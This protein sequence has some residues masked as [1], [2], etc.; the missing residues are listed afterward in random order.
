MFVFIWFRL[1]ARLKRF[2]E[3]IFVFNKSRLR[4]ER[5]GNRY[6]A[7]DISTFRLPIILIIKSIIL[8]FVKVCHCFLTSH[9]WAERIN[10]FPFTVEKYFLVAKVFDALSHS[11]SCR[12]IWA[13]L[14]AFKF[15]ATV[16]L[17]LKRSRLEQDKNLSG[18]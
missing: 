13:A 1:L 2:L 17:W 14:K 4:A 10:L 8:S 6:A 3:T 12:I 18:C 15:L 11:R 9:P 5:F 7:G 16:V